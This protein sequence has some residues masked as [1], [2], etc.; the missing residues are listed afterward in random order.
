MWI[1]EK[2]LQYPVDVRIKDPKLAKTIMTQYGG[3]NGEL[4][5][6]LRYLSQRYTMPTGKAKGLLTDIGTEELAHLEMVATIIYQL[7]QDADGED[8]YNATAAALY[9]K[10]D[11][12]I[13]PDD[14]GTVPFTSAYIN[15]M[16]TDYIADLYEDLAAEQKARATYEY[17]LNITNEPSVVEPISFL[18]QR[19]VIHFQR[20]G[21]LLDDLQ[22]DKNIRKQFFMDYNNFNTH[23]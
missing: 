17:I 1:Y 3:P 16:G 7:S 22:F 14:S 8:F 10:W 11:K 5:A 15:T 4:A 12:G 6:A 19:E 21:E 13:H 9:A 2:K 23:K 18:R 20:F